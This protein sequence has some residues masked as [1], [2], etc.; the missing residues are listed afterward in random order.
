MNW[1]RKLVWRWIDGRMRRQEEEKKLRE[2]NEEIERR[3]RILRPWVAEM[4]KIERH[5]IPWE[6]FRLMAALTQRAIHGWERLAFHVE[7]GPRAEPESA[8]PAKSWWQAPG[9]R[10]Q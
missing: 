2:R 9:R 10:I 6:E 3:L 5:E 1:A 8:I 4:L 7:S